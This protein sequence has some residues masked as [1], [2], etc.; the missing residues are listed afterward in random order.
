MRPIRILFATAEASPYAKVGGLGDVIGSLPAVLNQSGCDAR[1]ILPLYK[2]IKQQYIGQMQFLGW[3]MVKMGWRS[4]Y[5]GL[6]SIVHDGVTYYFVD[7]EYYF[8]HDRIYV[9]YAFDMERFCFFQR[10]AL[11]FMGGFMDFEPDVLHCN[12]WQTGMMPLLLDVHY[13]SRHIHDA[14]KTVYTIHNLKYQGVHSTE[15]IRD[16][17]DLPEPYVTEEFCIKDDA[18]NFMK[19]GIVFANTVT[20]VSPTYAAEIMTPYFGEGLDGL[21]RH[22][23]YKVT[24]ILNGINAAEFDPA[25][26]ELLVQTYDIATWQTGKAANKQAVQEKLGLEPNPDAPL[27]VMISRLV[28]QKGLDL[29]LHVLEE[30]LF[31]GMQVV[32]EGL[33][34]IYYESTLA[35]IANRHPKQMN[36]YLAYD[37]E[38]AH[39]LYAAADVFLMPSLFEPCGLSQMISMRYGTIPVVRETGGLKDTVIPY[40]EVE[41][42][43]T[44]FSYAN[45]NAHEFLFTT[46]YACNTFRHKRDAWNRMVERGMSG[47]FSWQ[48]SAREYVGVYSLITGISLQGEESES[49]PAAPAKAVPKTTKKPASTTKK[50]GDTKSVSGKKTVKKPVASPAKTSKAE[51]P[52]SPSTRSPVKKN[53]KPKKE[54]NIE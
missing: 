23:S 54:L 17:L 53:T 25:S 47:D 43:G 18:V 24:G 10:A 3:Q 45:I 51:A 34:D 19:A 2:T 52:K 13:K 21:L 35:E 46:K 4:L 31:D 9:E 16:L 44:G 1:V 26:D 36:A 15:V 6:F 41:D 39:R 22:V 38:M 40:N 50:T 28:D 20:T 33:G 37:N 5:A 30:M 7:N 14:V 27:C 8:N 48:V 12:D 49:E 32:I 42:A 11:D 29:L